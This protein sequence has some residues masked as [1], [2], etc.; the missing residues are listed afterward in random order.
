MDGVYQIAR[1]ATN[2]AQK[3]R[4]LKSVCLG[5][6]WHR[7]CYASVCRTEAVG[8]KLWHDVRP[9]KETKTHAYN[10]ILEYVK[11]SVVSSIKRITKNCF[12]E[13]QESPITWVSLSHL[14]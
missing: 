6:H 9:F 2:I 1:S 10:N 7:R 12:E 13:V 11:Y 8:H 14:T 3:A 5:Q 4:A